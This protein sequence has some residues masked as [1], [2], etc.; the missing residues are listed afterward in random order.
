MHSICRAYIGEAS[1]QALVNPYCCSWEL[2][3]SICFASV[4]GSQHVFNYSL[5]LQILFWAAKKVKLDR[6]ILRTLIAVAGKWQLR[7][8]ISTERQS[9]FKSRY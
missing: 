4:A 8:R 1:S 9:I 3:M 5:P 2:S 7:A 6:D